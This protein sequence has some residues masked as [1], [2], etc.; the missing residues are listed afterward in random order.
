MWSKCLYHWVILLVT[1]NQSHDYVSSLETEHF[2]QHLGSLCE[3]AAS[4][5]PR[6]Q[7]QHPEKGKDDS[8]G[9]GARTLG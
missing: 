8:S 7:K 1:V 2:N 4:R 6:A 9:G 3:D 5:V